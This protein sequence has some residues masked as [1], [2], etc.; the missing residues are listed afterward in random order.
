MEA[1]MLTITIQDQALQSHLQ[2]LRTRLQDL[3]PAME[4]IGNALE[5]RVR[6]RFQTATDPNG[7]KW[8]PWKPSTVASYPF[9]GTR[10][11]AKYGAGNARLLDR[12]GTMLG[13]LNYQAGGTSVTVGFAAPYATFHEF[14]TKRMTRRGMLMANPDNGTL[15]QEDQSEVLNIINHWLTI[16]ANP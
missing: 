14:G 12:Y 7:A 16:S 11:A 5:T 8:A 3:T 15:G 1:P 10:A 4:E 6:Q 13:G 9:P 2:L